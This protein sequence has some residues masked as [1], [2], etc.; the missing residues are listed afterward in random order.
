MS[1]RSL[2]VV[3]LLVLLALLAASCA[4]PTAP[5]A[6]APEAAEPAAG[7]EA[8]D[9]SG[10]EELTILWA[11]WDPADYLQE[12]GNLYEEETGIKVNVVQEPWGSFYDRAFTEF[13]AGGDSFD[14]IVG[15]SQWLGQG[16]E[17]GHYVELTDFMVGEGIDKTVTPATL[18]YY[19][20]YPTGSGKYWAFP[21]EG[22]AVGWAYRSRLLRRPGRAGRVRG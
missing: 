1:K 22:D 19:G 4:A 9:A 6:A 18:T 21:T 17:Q 13:A 16:A 10:V 2:L 7:G 5:D 15:D 20:E 3:V 8:A 11:Q 12:I 14:M